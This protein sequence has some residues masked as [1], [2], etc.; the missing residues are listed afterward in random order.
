MPDMRRDRDNQPPR[1]RGKPSLKPVST[2]VIHFFQ[3]SRGFGCDEETQ[4]CGH[5]GDRHPPNFRAV[6][7]LSPHGLSHVITP[8]WTVGL[9]ADAASTS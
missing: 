2:Q 3:F 6:A 4:E 5:K 1:M 9:R 8:N 7:P